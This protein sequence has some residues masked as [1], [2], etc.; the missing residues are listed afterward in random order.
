M[1]GIGWLS[2]HLMDAYMF[3]L[4][5]YDVKTC[6]LSSRKRSFFAYTMLMGEMSSTTSETT[7]LSNP[8]I[9][10]ER[11]RNIHGPEKEAK[12]WLCKRIYVPINET[13]NHW[14]GMIIYPSKKKM[15]FYDSL[16]NQS[17]SMVIFGNRMK[18]Y[19]AYLMDWM[20]KLA[21]DD[22][23]ALNNLKAEDWHYEVFNGARQRDGFN[24]GVFVLMTFDFLLDD[25]NEKFGFSWD[26]ALSPDINYFRQKIT[27][28][29]W[30]RSLNYE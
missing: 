2:K 19:K 16:A 21:G 27:V 15:R 14:T 22:Q 8:P 30:R 5:E 24:C 11:F 25:L 3:L 28:D 23:E 13:N 7:S 18:R 12:P 26:V 6:R 4:Y 10:A 20:Q 9:T 29:L 1:E 17:S